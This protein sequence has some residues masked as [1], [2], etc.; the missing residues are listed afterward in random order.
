MRKSKPLRTIK[1][2]LF[3][4]DHF[5]MEEARAAVLAVM[6]ERG[7][8]PVIDIVE[9]VSPRGVPLRRQGDRPEAA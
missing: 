9:E 8:T 5:T 4:P 1:A 6:A 3:P 2:P 7:E